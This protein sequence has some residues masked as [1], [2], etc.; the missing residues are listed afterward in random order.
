MNHNTPTPELQA[1]KQKRVESL[2][3]DIAM[4]G[5][6]DNDRQTVL[7]FIRELKGKAPIIF[8]PEQIIYRT[9]FNLL[10]ELKSI[11]AQIDV[12]RLAIKDLGQSETDSAAT[13]LLDVIN[14]LCDL[15]EEQEL[16]VKT[17][18]QM[19]YHENGG[20]Q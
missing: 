2:D 16:M 5:L 6:R 18:E 17:L 19:A 7:D 4:F 3:I 1:L 15:I 10:Y 11:Y 14:L 12:S 13:V 9:Q 8:I 20:D